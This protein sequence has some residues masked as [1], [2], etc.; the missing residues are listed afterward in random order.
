MPK[1]DLF[2]GLI[3]MIELIADKETSEEDKVMS[4]HTLW[5]LMRTAA[6]EEV[7]AEMEDQGLQKLEAVA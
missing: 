6:R 2:N 3:E 7:L 5:E 4:A 1:S